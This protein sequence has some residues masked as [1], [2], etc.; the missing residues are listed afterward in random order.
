MEMTRGTHGSL[1]FS[2]RS[3]RESCVPLLVTHSARSLLSTFVTHSPRS[4]RGAGASVASGRNGKGM[5]EAR[6]FRT[7]HSPTFRSF[8]VHLVVILPPILT[9]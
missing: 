3:F 2:Y 1:H 5:E 8:A 7:L 6:P 9:A 4:C